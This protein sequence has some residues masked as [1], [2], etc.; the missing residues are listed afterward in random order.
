MNAIPAVT[1]FVCANSG[2]PQATRSWPF[3]AREV[4]V[5]CTGKLQPEHLLKAFEAGADLVCVVACD[6]DNCHTLEG[7]R[8]AVR[9]VQFVKRILDETGVGG[10]R[11][12]LVHLRGSADKGLDPDVGRRLADLSK[13]IADRFE[14]LG[15]CPLRKD[16]LPT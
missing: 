2:R 15:T 13:E 16:D 3:A 4:L 1:M 6:G 14:A 5:P 7:S 12:I 11:L 9:R 10:E 8:R